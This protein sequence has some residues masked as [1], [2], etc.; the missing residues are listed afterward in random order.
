MSLETLS[1]YFFIFFIFSFVG[2]IIEVI[3]KY[4]D[5]GKFVNRGFLVGP[6][7]P[8]YGLGGLLIVLSTNGLKKYEYSYALVFLTS[9]VIC[10]LVEYFV[11]YYLEKKYH[12]RWWDYSNKPMNLNGRIW[13]GNLVL[14]GLGGLFIVEIFSPLFLS[15]FYKLTSRSRIIFSIIVAIIMLSDYIVS[16][17]VMKLIKVNIEESKA[18][19]TEEIK[20][21][22][23][24]LATNK[25]I[26][27]SR[28]VNAY[29][30][31]KYRTDRIKNRIK[32]IEDES[33]RIRQEVEQALDEE[34]ELLRSDLKPSYLIKN[35]IIDKQDAL[36]SLLE[37]EDSSKDEI[38]D[39]KVQ[40]N[41]SKDLLEKRKKLIN[42]DKID[43]LRVH[44]K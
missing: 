9:L 27:Y 31:V 18:D 14:F 43:K 23:K 13:I 42:G 4:F 6:Y 16:Y 40:I 1:D 3:L 38:E 30:D 10:G 34:K 21:E 33:R 35:E 7:C 25:N 26:L 44:N 29:P 41:E 24:E 19:N 11:S 37:D 20:A 39:L 17:F 2:W 15:Y 8:I 5:L 36:I 32:E 12:A 22:M 28:F